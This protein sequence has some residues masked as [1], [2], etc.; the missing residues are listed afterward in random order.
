MKNYLNMTK[1]QLMEQLWSTQPKIKQIL[2]N[3][4]HVEEAR[5]VLFDYMN[6][7]ERDLYNLKSDTYFENLNISEKRN[8]KE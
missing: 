4:R 5:H 1:E 8:A 7:L 2:R 3:S 6:R